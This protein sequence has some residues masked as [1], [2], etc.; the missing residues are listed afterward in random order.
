MAKELGGRESRKRMEPKKGKRKGGR[1]VEVK[2]GG[3]YV[4]G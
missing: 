3:I 1:K 4:R 2:G